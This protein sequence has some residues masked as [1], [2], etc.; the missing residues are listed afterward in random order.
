MKKQKRHLLFLAIILL[1]HDQISFAQ[2]QEKI[3][4][5]MILNFSRGMHWPGIQTGKFIIGVFEYPPLVSELNE[6]AST[7][8]IGSRQ[9]EIKEYSDPA[10]ISKCNVLFVP[11]YKAKRIPDV[12]HSIGNDPTLIVTNKMDYARKGAGINFLLLQGKLKYEINCAAIEKRGIKIS[13]NVK[14]LGIIVN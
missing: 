13:T 12:L 10:D 11:S 5:V 6:I 14:K 7:M 1:F 9:I 3:Y 8:K 4:S 2:S